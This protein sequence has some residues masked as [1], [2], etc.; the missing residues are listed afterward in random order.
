MLHT[1]LTSFSAVLFQSLITLPVIRARASANTDYLGKRFLRTPPLS[2]PRCLS[3]RRAD[4]WRQCPL[5]VALGLRTALHLHMFSYRCSDLPAR[6][7]PRSPRTRRQRLFH[8]R[9]APRVCMRSL[10]VGRLRLVTAEPHRLYC[11][12]CIRASCLTRTE[13]FIRLLHS[14]PH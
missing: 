1:M 11:G 13:R 8:N 4:P 7:R 5:L 9:F 14:G 6:R 12:M 10:L 2:R 3:T